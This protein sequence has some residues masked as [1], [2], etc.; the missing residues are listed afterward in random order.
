MTHKIKIFQAVIFCVFMKTQNSV[1]QKIIPIDQS[2]SD[3]FR[4][5]VR[6]LES[7][8]E[9]KS[10]HTLYRKTYGFFHTNMN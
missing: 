7:A 5:K 6:P 2:K 1:S 10:L 8:V 9:T 3:I 4:T